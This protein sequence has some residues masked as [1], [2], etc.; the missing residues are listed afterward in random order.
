MECVGMQVRGGIIPARA[1]STARSIVSRYALKDHPRS[2]GEH[3]AQIFRMPSTMGSSPLAR[4]ALLVLVA[5]EL[6]LRII[7]ARAGSTTSRR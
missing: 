7:P 6:D 2:R 3:P 4:G 1:G 5:H